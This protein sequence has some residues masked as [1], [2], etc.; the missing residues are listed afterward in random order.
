[1]PVFNNFQK[2][3]I[4]FLYYFQ[5]RYLDGFLRA[6]GEWLLRLSQVEFSTIKEEPKVPLVS[7]QKLNVF[8]TMMVDDDE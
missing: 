5:A 1:V 7:A 4:R 8:A 2:I 3:I 6:E